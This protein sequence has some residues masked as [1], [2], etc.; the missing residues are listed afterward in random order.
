MLLLQV[1]TNFKSG[2]RMRLQQTHV[3]LVQIMKG[4][5]HEADVALLM[6]SQHYSSTARL[7]LRSA[8]LAR[9]LWATDTQ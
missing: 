7:L 9:C 5:V 8:A 2:G 4:I 1:K 6:R 3:V